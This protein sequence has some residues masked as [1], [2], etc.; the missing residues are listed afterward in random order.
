MCCSPAKIVSAVIRVPESRSSTYWR[1]SG[2]TAL[3]RSTFWFIL[4]LFFLIASVVF[5]AH[6]FLSTFTIGTR[7]RQPLSGAFSSAV[8]TTFTLVIHQDWVSVAFVTEGWITAV[9]CFAVWAASCVEDANIISVKGVSMIT[10]F[11]GWISTIEDLIYAI[12]CGQFT[13]DWWVRLCQN[14]LHVITITD[15]S[16]LE[17]VTYHRIVLDVVGDW[18]FFHPSFFCW[19]PIYRQPSYL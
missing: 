15:Y 2:N 18:K 3:E 7:E 1:I 17:K 10:I 11:A 12:V 13:F 5:I 4:I 16:N 6:K 9:T 14:I 19:I 8:S